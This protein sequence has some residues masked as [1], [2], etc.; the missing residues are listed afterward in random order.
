MKNSNCPW[1][2]HKINRFKDQQGVRKRKTPSRLRFAKCSHCLHY[3]G[4]NVKSKRN[5]IA[6]IAIVLSLILSICFQNAYMLLLIFFFLGIVVTSPLE[7]MTDDE[8]VFEDVKNY[9][10]NINTDS[11]S[12]RL[13]YYK[14]V[15]NGFFD[16]DFVITE[17]KKYG[18]FFYNICEVRMC[19]YQSAVAIFSSDNL[20]EPLIDLKPMHPYLT[21][22]IVG[23]KRYFYAP[24]S[25]CIITGCSIHN[26]DI[27]FL[28][29]KPAEK[30]FAMI[31]FD[32]TS[33]YYLL[34]EIE[35]GKIIIED[36]STDELKLLEEKG[37][38]KKTGKQFTLS[39]LNW[40]DITEFE[41]I[42]KIYLDIKDD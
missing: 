35:K 23:Y 14:T 10:W 42:E 16:E 25:D 32:Y 39:N 20:N 31:P 7:K 40:Y 6:F 8:N 17:D 34:N 38:V 24:L 37:Y 2:G 27:P 21:G 19:S 3:Y 18:I 9:K 4:Q 26:K 30:K 12:K 36:K 1:C 15:P 5:V 41:K 11:L 29:I 22:P 28:L 13:S 33:I